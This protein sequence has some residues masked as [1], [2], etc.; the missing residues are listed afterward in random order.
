MKR[1]LLFCLMILCIHQTKAQFSGKG[2][3]T[4]E[5]PYLI[6]EALNVEEIRNFQNKEGVVFKLEND[7]NMSELIEDTYGEDGWYPIPDFR[8]ELDGNGFTISGLFINR[9]KLKSVGFFSNITYAKIHNLLLEYDGD[10]IGAENVGGICGTCEFV[11]V[12]RCGIRGKN[13]IS[14]GQ[15]YYSDGTSSP[16]HGNIG[17]LIGSAK[18]A[19]IKECIVETT[20]IFGSHCGGLAGEA[21]D[22]IISDNRVNVNDIMGE[23]LVN[24]M[25][26]Y[27]WVAGIVASSYRNTINNNLFEGERITNKGRSS[28]TGG[29]VGLSHS[30]GDIYSNVEICDSIIIYN[31]SVGRIIGD[32][33]EVSITDPKAN[34]AYN[35][36]VLSYGKNVFDVTDNE[37]NGLS[38]GSILLKSKNLYKG[39]GWDMDEVWTIDDGNAYPRL[40]WEVEQGVSKPILTIQAQDADITEDDVLTFYAEK[41]T[42]NIGGGITYTYYQCVPDEPLIINTSS[43]TQ[44]V[45]VT[46][47]SEDYSHLKWSGINGDGRVNWNVAQRLH[48]SYTPFLLINILALI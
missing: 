21:V 45:R 26:D 41:V 4:A 14:Q 1:I 25:S 39:M 28:Y 3:G 7:V 2:S 18:G 24:S 36:T 37:K 32:G 34:R 11:E 27:L 16:V 8:G 23:A 17:G 5:D 44:Q 15:S 22:G 19:T 31:S 29:I 47:S 35:K 48:L 38:V 43:R 10:I 13:I 12:C 40:K 6:T 30:K 9:P 20:M 46:I 42:S 33:K